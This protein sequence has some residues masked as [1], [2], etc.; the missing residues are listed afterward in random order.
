M[1]DFENDGRDYNENID[2]G[3]VD[4]ENE[5]NLW[6][7]KNG[8][9]RTE[10]PEI[11]GIELKK[12]RSCNCKKQ[13]FNKRSYDS[14]TSNGN[15]TGGKSNKN[16]KKS[17]SASKTKGGRKKKERSLVNPFII[18]YLEM[19]YKH[20]TKCVAEIAAAAG[21]VWGNMSA[22]EKAEY[23]KKAR[24]ASTKRKAAQLE[25]KRMRKEKLKKMRKR[26]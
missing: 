2:E 5:F 12:C 21:R 7:Q 15:N 13:D 17:S 23:I 20:P 9:T 1:D 8:N 19:Y 18:F 26:C 14:S 25:L 16:N 22:K 10:L 24:I 6:V 11:R 3:P 4:E